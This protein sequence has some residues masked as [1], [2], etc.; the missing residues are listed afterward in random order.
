MPAKGRP[1]EDECRLQWADGR[2]DAGGDDVADEAGDTE[3]GK[4]RRHRPDRGPG[5]IG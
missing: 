3:G 2:D 4:E 5:I 1:E